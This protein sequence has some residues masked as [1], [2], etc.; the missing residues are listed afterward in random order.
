MRRAISVCEGTLSFFCIGFTAG[1]LTW[2]V[3]ESA[4]NVKLAMLVGLGMATV[5]LLL[6]ATGKKIGAELNN[7]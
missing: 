1:F 2:F 7:D 6:F 3:L 4:P 5:R